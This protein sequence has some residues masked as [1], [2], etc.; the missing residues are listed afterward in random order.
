MFSLI[1]SMNKD[2]ED[3]IE[4]QLQNENVKQVEVY[5]QIISYI[6]TRGPW[7]EYHSKVFKTYYNIDQ[8]TE[9]KIVNHKITSAIYKAVGI[10]GS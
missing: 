8:D 7:G 10:Q 6:W 5:D 2:R 3:Y 9:L 1:F 4:K